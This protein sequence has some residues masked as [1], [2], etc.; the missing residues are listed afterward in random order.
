MSWPIK[1]ELNQINSSS[2]NVPKLLGKSDARN[3]EECDQKLI[4][5]EEARNELNHQI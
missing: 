2:E 5:V 3:S 1:F 4:R